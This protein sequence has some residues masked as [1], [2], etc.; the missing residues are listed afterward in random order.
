MKQWV[1]KLMQQLDVIENNE[2]SDNELMLPQ[3]SDE[4]ATLLFIIDIY[5]KHLFDMDK[6]S[7]R[8]VRGKLD[9]LAKQLLNPDEKVTENTLFEIRQFFSSYRIDECS[10]IQN[11]FDDFKRIVWDFADNLSEDLR[12]ENSR[13]KKLAIN[14]NE[15]KEAVEANSI[16]TLRLKSREFINAYVE[17]QAQKNDLRDRRISST[18]KNLE[19]VKMQ[20]IEAHQNLQLDHLTG[21]NNRKSFDDYTRKLTQEQTEQQPP[22]SMILMDIDYFK[23]INDTYGHDVGDVVLKE[24]VK[25]LKEAFPGEDEMVA[26]IG[27][28]EFIVVLPEHGLKAAARRAQEAMSLIRNAIVA[29]GHHTIQYTVSMGIAELQTNEDSSLWLKRCDTALYQSKNGGR[30]RYTL[31]PSQLP[32]DSVA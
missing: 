7:V 20:L 23:K 25:T 4:K 13:E 32:L 24:C 9:E 29:A 28:E 26:R 18:R 21:A 10:Y 6:H 8:K 12:F 14:L 19:D 5:N 16:D 15:L 30:N 17:Y 2:D 31:A 3:I 22:S 27:G 1:V 11:T